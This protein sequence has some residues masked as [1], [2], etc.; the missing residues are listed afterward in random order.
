MVVLALRAGV[1]M[2]NVYSLSWEIGVSGKRVIPR[3][4][5]HVLA[6]NEVRVKVGHR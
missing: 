5:V 2:E 1:G 6:A 3:E 4:T